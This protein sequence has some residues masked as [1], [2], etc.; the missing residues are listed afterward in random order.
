MLIE[1]VT[2]EPH[3]CPSHAH[4]LE[5][6]LH[7]DRTDVPM[8]FIQ[9]MRS[10]DRSEVKQSVRVAG[11]GRGSV[12]RPEF[13]RQ[14]RFHTVARFDRTSNP[15]HAIS[16]PDSRNSGTVDYSGERVIEHLHTHERILGDGHRVRTVPQ[17]TG[18]DPYCL[19]DLV[20]A[21]KPENLELVHDTVVSLGRAPGHGKRSGY[22]SDPA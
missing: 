5:S 10:Q 3:R 16:A 18:S 1:L 7:P 15:K 4:G 13:R 12:D 14:H 21:I 22:R 8:G 20:G 17:R 11:R 19:G 2:Q 9:V 6:R